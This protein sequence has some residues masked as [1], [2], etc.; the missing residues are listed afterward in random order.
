MTVGFHQTAD[1]PHQAVSKVLKGQLWSRPA[2]KL[3][4]SC[5]FSA[6]VLDIPLGEE[7]TLPDD[8][9]SQFMVVETTRNGL[10]PQ[11]LICYSV[12]KRPVRSSPDPTKDAQRL[13]TKLMASDEVETYIGTFERVTTWEGWFYSA[14]ANILVPFLLGKAQDAYYALMA[15]EAGSSSKSA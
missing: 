11:P 1:T 5:H 10:G 14:W 2:E 9:G 4:A 6:S 8:P 12:V 15:E 13:L 3:P 7:V